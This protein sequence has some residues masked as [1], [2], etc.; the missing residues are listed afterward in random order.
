[1]CVLGGIGVVFVQAASLLL[2]VA[3]VV[4][5]VRSLIAVCVRMSRPSSRSWPN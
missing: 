4:V 3:M 2:M 1:M 5:V